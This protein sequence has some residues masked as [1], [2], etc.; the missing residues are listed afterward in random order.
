MISDR[1]GEMGFMESMVSMMAVTIVIGLY[2][3][4]VAT[5]A[6]TT[7]APLNDFDPKSAEITLGD[8]IEMSESYL[9][10]FLA[11][12]KVDGIS[13]TV[14]VPIF[15]EESR[16]FTVGDTSGPEYSATYLLLLDHSGGRKVPAVAEVRA[17]L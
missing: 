1:H 13:V 5:S 7:Y 4:F 3:A 6:A 14:S 9:Y 10:M 17:Y 8:G 2:I 11:T 12:G 15:F 16:T